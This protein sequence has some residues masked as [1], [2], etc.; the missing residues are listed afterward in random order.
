MKNATTTITILVIAILTIFSFNTSFAQYLESFENSFYPTGW[1]GKGFSKTN[2]KNKSGTYSAVSSQNNSNSDENYMEIE[3]IST[4]ISAN[5]S[6]SFI[7]HSGSKNTR[8]SV[9]IKNSSINNGDSTFVSELTPDKSNWQ[10]ANIDIPT[11]YL[12]TQN[13]SVYFIVNKVGNGGNDKVYLDDVNTS[14]PMPVE[15]KSFTYNV[16]LNTVSL[17]WKTNAEI[18]NKGFEVQRNSGNGWTVIGFV[19]ANSSKSYSFSDNNLKTGTYQYRLKQID[20]NG[21]FEYFNL[22]GDIKIGSP[23]KFSL[24]QNYPNP[25]NPST[26]ISFQIPTDEFVTLKVYDNTGREVMS[27]VNETKTA[28]YHTVELKSSLTSGIYYYV[29]KAGSFTDTKKMSVIK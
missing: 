19:N 3:N 29:L 11:N 20:F 18:N 27:L 23:V 24:S 15:M 10:T 5:I 25:F 13:T 6:F 28:G 14:F 26:K 2:S 1:S 12:N 7:G 4:S 9:Y 8:I 17:N 21:N 22:N 16:K